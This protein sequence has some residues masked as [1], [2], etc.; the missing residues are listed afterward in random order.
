MVHRKEKKQA[1]L[2]TR[3]G[4]GVAIYDQPDTARYSHMAGVLNSNESNEG[5]YPLGGPAI[6]ELCG[7]SE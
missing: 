2:C 3:E 4:V 1:F 6:L 5:C 7:R